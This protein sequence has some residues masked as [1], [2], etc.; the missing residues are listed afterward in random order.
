MV[1]GR[2]GRLCVEGNVGPEYADCGVEE[3]FP[4]LINSVALYATAQENSGDCV[5]YILRYEGSVLARVVEMGVVCCD[6]CEGGIRL[7][8]RHAWM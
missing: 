8:G 2:F 1:E 4:S 5:K 6:R 3:C 7:G